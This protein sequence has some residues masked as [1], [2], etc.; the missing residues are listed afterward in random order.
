[1]IELKERCT[2]EEIQAPKSQ[3]GKEEEPESKSF[4][5]LQDVALEKFG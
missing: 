4:T 1:M 2:I 3:N 5:D